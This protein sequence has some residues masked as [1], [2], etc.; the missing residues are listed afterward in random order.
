V[1][2]E[3]RQSAVSVLSKIFAT[4][5]FLDIEPQEMDKV[6]GSPVA[7]PPNPPEVESQSGGFIRSRI[8]FE[9][10]RSG[11]ISL[12]LPA[13]LAQLMSKNFLGLEEEEPSKSQTSDMAGELANIISGNLL[14]ALDKKGSY[15][16]SL[17]QTE[18]GAH[19]EVDHPGSRSGCA[20]DF[21]V[22]G[23]WVQF[24]IFFDE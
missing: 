12:I 22:E 24:S 3:M 4:M 9:G 23:Q 18:T 2:E 21:D 8:R 14:P 11:M 19:P 20:I 15:S 1:F 13:A 5:F 17:P 16:L 10:P 6:P 7:L